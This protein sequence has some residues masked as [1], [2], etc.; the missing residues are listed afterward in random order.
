MAS[1]AIRK[2]IPSVFSGCAHFARPSHRFTTLFRT[3]RT[4]VDIAFSTGRL[5]RKLLLS[6]HLLKHQSGRHARGKNHREVTPRDCIELLKSNAAIGGW[7]PQT[8]RETPHRSRYSSMPLP[9]ILRGTLFLRGLRP[10]V[11]NQMITIQD[12]G[13]Y[14]RRVMV[15]SR[16]KATERRVGPQSD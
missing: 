5:R 9:M 11:D 2:S 1:S 14:C 13:N 15:F 10:E 4:A 3:A 16:S 6:Q 8:S 7:P 12:P